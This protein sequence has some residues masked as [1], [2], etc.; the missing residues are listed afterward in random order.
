MS[1]KEGKKK[2]KIVKECKINENFGLLENKRW[3]KMKNKSSLLWKNYAS[4]PLEVRI[5]LHK[6]SAQADPISVK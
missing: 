6:L 2:I 5:M 1:S 4:P 3:I